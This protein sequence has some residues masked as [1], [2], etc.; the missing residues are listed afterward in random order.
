MPGKTLGVILAS[1]PVTSGVRTTNMVRRAAEALGFDAIEIA[2]LFPKAT[3]DTGEISLLGSEERFWLDARPA[4]ESLLGRSEGLL[5]AWGVGSCTGSA[6]YWWTDQLKWTATTAA[7]FGHT[8][9][10]TLG[11]GPRHPSRWHQY[12]SDKYGRAGDGT[13]EARISRALQLS[14]LS[15]LCLPKESSS[16]RA[17]SSGALVLPLSASGTTPEPFHTCIHP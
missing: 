7:V 16:S 17:Q 8:Q 1:P 10:W 14:P 12:V 3:R 2:N 11:P 13:T 15:G 4:L 6:R 5:A 9:A